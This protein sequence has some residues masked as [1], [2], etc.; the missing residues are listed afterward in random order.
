MKADF[1]NRFGVSC[2]A[3]VWVASAASLGQAQILFEENWNSGSINSANWTVNDDGAVMTVI[4]AVDG[5]AGD[6]ALM[7][8][9]NNGWG[10]TISSVA[11]YSRA[12]N[13]L[14]LYIEFSTWVEGGVG[15]PNQGLQA[16][17]HRVNHPAP[18]PDPAA[19]IGPFSIELGTDGNWFGLSWSE[20]ATFDAGPTLSGDDGA[21]GA[22]F[23]SRFGHSQDKSDALRVRFTLGATQGGMI[24]WFNTDTNEWVVEGDFREGVT[25]TAQQGLSNAANVILGFESFGQ[26]G[27]TAVDTAT[28]TVVRNGVFI[29]DIVVG[30]VELPTGACNLPEGAGGSCQLLTEADCLAQGGT[31]KGDGIVCP[32]TIEENFDGGSINP[33]LWTVNDDGAVTTLVNAIDGVA[34]DDALMI[35]GNTSWGQTISSVANYSRFGCGHGIY[36]EFTTWVEGGVGAPNQGFH[37]PFHRVNPPAPSPDPAAPIGPFSVEMGAEWSWF[38]MRWSENATFNAG[39]N[40]SGDDGAIGATFQSRFGHSHDKNDALRVRFTLGA[41]QGGM[42]EWFNTDI[43]E[44]TEEVV[45]WVVEGDFREGVTGTAQQGLSSATNVIIGFESFGENPNAAVDT[46][47]GTVVRN[48]VFID[49]IVIGTIV[50]P[51]GACNIAGDGSCQIL[52][53]AECMAQGG[54]Y[55]GDDT[56]CGTSNIPGDCNQD[57][58]FD[59]S[60]VICLLGHLF[61]GNPTMLP[62]GTTAGTATAAE[63]N[64]M[65][66]NNDDGI[67]LSDAIYNLAFLFQGSPP[68]FAGQGCVEIVPGCPQNTSCP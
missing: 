40:L 57:G 68:P 4:N 66:S 47:T 3:L 26:N 7:I 45:G 56:S 59:L 51:T 46:T 6:D 64:L 14:G 41:T 1:I 13:G 17:F 22:T 37:A 21:I 12:G 67:D 58:A 29:D 36:V 42:I 15:A 65:D 20:N 53:E 5:V 16:P 55:E 32:F 19:P 62:C 63:L 2:A 54:T 11:N 44:E 24:E 30:N 28:G 25:G 61:Q 52:T 50:P 60:D 18:S 39:P 49:D 43:D 23:Q 33:A 34:G 38:A 10:Q 9:G 48:G 8:T 31:Y 35:T 27:N